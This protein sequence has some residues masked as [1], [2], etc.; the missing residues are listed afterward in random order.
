MGRRSGAE[1]AIT[2]GP[3]SQSGLGGAENLVGMGT[4]GLVAGRRACRTVL[5]GRVGAHTAAPAAELCPGTTALEFSLHASLF[6][7][8]A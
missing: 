7:P 5:F 4:E 3:S 8:R 6:S 2:A 1:G